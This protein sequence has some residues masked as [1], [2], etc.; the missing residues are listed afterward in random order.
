MLLL[1]LSAS[2]RAGFNSRPNGSRGEHCTNQDTLR[3]RAVLVRSLDSIE[4][5]L[6]R[7]FDNGLP[8]RRHYEYEKLVARISDIWSSGRPKAGVQ[9]D[10]NFTK[11]RLF[12]QYCGGKTVLF[13]IRPKA[14]AAPQTQ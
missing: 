1:H 2:E 14:A 9:R 8:G 7:N 4:W 12:L 5:S 3:A 6:L 13:S 10:L 11:F